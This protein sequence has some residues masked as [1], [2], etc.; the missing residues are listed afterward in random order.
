M[1]S[2]MDMNRAKVRKV[3]GVTSTSES[4]STKCL[5]GFVTK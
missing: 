4:K 2:S 1:P 5:A 3:E